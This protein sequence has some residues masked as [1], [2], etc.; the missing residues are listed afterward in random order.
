MSQ[1]AQTQP[2][3]QSAD[4]QPA[5]SAPAPRADG[6]APGVPGPRHGRLDGSPP[7]APA[8]G[9]WRRSWRAAALLWLATHAVYAVVTV[10]HHLVAPSPGVSVLGTWLRWD[11]PRYLNIAEGGYEAH[12][13]EVAFF[14]LYPVLTALADPLLPGDLL[15]AAMVAAN[16]AGLG[17]MVLLHR[18]VTEEFGGTVAGRT[19]LLLAVFPS[20]FFLAAPFSH[21]LFLL[22]ALGFLYAL[23]HQR[24]WLAGL[25]GGLASGTRPFGVLLV[26]P[27]VFEYLHHLPVGRHHEGAGVVGRVIARLRRVRAGAAAVALV[28]L[29]AA[30]FAAY[31]WVTFGDP[32]AYSHAQIEG[33]DKTVTWPGHTLWLTV[34]QLLARPLLENRSVLVDLTSALLAIG[35]V[36]ISVVGRWR[37]PREQWYLVVYAVAIL[38]LPLCV[39]GIP[40]NPVMSMTRYLVDICVLFVVVSRLQPTGPGRLAAGLRRVGL[41]PALAVPLAGLQ[42]VF[43]WDYLGG[44]WVF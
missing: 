10:A 11:A 9:S 16:L 14:P 37:L 43:L 12:P 2:A 8:A 19:L 1:P 28:P 29:G 32:L 6:A 18:L 23:R 40:T 26:V 20:A 17:A 5:G 31:C 7:E 41:V 15:V 36:V 24:W 35:L 38:L 42:L 3:A 44:D 21:S 34:E 4:T 27:F 30:S 25:L 22:L 13:Q 39:T 33:W